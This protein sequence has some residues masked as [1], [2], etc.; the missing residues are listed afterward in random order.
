ML[1][2]IVVASLFAGLLQLVS[3]LAVLMYQPKMQAIPRYVIGT[4][5]MLM[6][7]TVLLVI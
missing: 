6:P 3:H 1:F 2:L 5:G 4:V 7:V